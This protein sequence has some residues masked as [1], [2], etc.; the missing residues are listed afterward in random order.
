[1]TRVRGRLSNATPR[2]A[3]WLV[4]VSS[5]TR[6][7]TTPTELIERL[8]PARTAKPHRASRMATSTS[9]TG[10]RKS[11]IGSRSTTTTSA[12]SSYV[13]GS[14]R[15]VLAV[16]RNRDRRRGMSYYGDKETYVPE[17]KVGDKVYHD[18]QPTFVRTVTTRKVRRNARECDTYYTLDNTCSEI[19]GAWEMNLQPVSELVAPGAVLSRIL[20]MFD[21]PLYVL[22]VDA[23]SFALVL[24]ISETRKVELFAYL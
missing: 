11:S 2:R 13:R 17:F 21:A 14:W 22:T 18:R 8:S 12:T 6:G 20:P 1:M 15:M 4:P 10:G 5:V 24:T 7:V 3:K 16:N 23:T 19:M 9:A